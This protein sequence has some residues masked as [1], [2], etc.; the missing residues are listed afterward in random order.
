MRQYFAPS[1]Q[2]SPSEGFP[3]S[4]RLF[5]KK[6]C[7]LKVDNAEEQLEEDGQPTSEAQLRVNSCN[8][9]YLEGFRDL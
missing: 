2:M 1:L 8:G 6:K 3:I 9:P 4:F 5:V 7:S